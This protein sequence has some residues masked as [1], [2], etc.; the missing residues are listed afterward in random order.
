[1]EGTYLGNFFQDVALLIL[2]ENFYSMLTL[3][4]ILLLLLIGLL[5][6]PVSLHIHTLSK[7]AYVNVW[8]IFYAKLLLVQS[9]PAIQLSFF[10]WKKILYP[11]RQ[12]RKEK[13]KAKEAA[14]TARKKWKKPA[15]LTFDRIKRILS[16]FKV[17]EFD[18]DIDTRD[19]VWNAYLFPISAFCLSKGYPIR[20]NY[21]N[22]FHLDLVIKNR[23]GSLLVALILSFFKPLK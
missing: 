14:K 4:L 6:A 15:F 10:S 23:L 12:K 22:R 19:V 8:K 17:Q 7:E 18:L 2:Q 3:I 1:M 11:L 21:M 20:I 13:A 16:S 5:L 9:E